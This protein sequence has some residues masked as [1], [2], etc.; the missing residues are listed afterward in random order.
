M[1]FYFDGEKIC[2]SKAHNYTH[3]IVYPAKPGTGKKWQLQS[4]HSSLALAQA[5]LA[6]TRRGLNLYNPEK[7]AALRL[8]ELEARP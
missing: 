8:V 2:T 6:N 3:A 4:R 7:A 1:K 5:A